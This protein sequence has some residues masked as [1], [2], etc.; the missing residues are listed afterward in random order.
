MDAF[1]TTVL[2]GIIVAVVGAIAAYYFGGV[3]EKRKQEYER[4]K[5]ERIRQEERQKD[6]NRRQIE[7]VDGLRSRAYS[8]IT[9]FTSWYRRSMVE[10]EDAPYDVA[11]QGDHF[12][13]TVKR[14][15]KLIEE[16]KEVEGQIRD[17]RLYYAEKT[18]YLEPE[19]IELIESFYKTLQSLHLRLMDSMGDLYW[20]YAQGHG[21]TSWWSDITLDEESSAQYHRAGQASLAARFDPIAW[22]YSPELEGLSAESKRLLG[23]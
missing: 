1:L 20:Y 13:S 21:R 7:A 18:P 11:I 8:A 5:E 2:A 22:D 12:E 19:T 3:R 15:P 9:A 17:L 16:G 4:Q 6:Q 14:F 10:G 23:E